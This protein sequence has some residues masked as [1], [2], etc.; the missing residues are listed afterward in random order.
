MSDVTVVSSEASS[1]ASSGSATSDVVAEASRFKVVGVVAAVA[2]GAG[3]AL[4]SIDGRAARAYGVGAVI[5]RD[6]VLQS[7]TQ[8]AVAVAPRA[9]GAALAGSL[10]C[11][12]T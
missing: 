2:G 1:S 9:G 7:V 10:P 3:V 12:L 11:P 8:K 4:L 6:W 5:E